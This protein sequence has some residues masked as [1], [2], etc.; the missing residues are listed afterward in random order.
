[1]ALKLILIYVWGCEKRNPTQI[2]MDMREIRSENSDFVILDR[3]IFYRALTLI[4]DRYDYVETSVA[5]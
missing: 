3:F 4:L 2:H 1:M 5:L